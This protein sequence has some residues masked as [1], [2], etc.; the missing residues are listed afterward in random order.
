MRRTSLLKDEIYLIL[1]NF[2][3]VCSVA[4]FIIPFKILSGGM[5]GVAVAIQPLVNIMFRNSNPHRPRL[6]KQ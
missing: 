1:G 3:L 5:A 4:Y 2:I 6:F